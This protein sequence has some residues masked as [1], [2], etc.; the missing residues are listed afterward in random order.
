[1]RSLA[2]IVLVAVVAAGFGCA[3]AN[4]QALARMSAQQRSFLDDKVGRLRADMSERHV[5]E[6]LGLP[7]RGSGEPRV[8]YAAPGSDKPTEVCVRFELYKARYVD[9]SVPGDNGFAY[10]IDLQQPKT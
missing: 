7:T 9:W 5:T 1:M 10:S 6:V 4:E 3:S 8:C 2:M